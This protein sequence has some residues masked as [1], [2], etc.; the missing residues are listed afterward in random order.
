[1]SELTSPPAGAPVPWTDEPPFDEA[2]LM[3]QVAGDRELLREISGLF[4]AESPRLREDVR[5]AIAAGDAGGLRKAA[6]TLKGA[7]SNFGATA[8]VAAAKA[9]EAMAR[10][11][12]L[13]GAAAGRDRLEEA[14]RRFEEALLRLQ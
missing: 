3:E 11:G 9:L 4:C 13:S 5:S 8:V 7:A 1:M 6:H 2:A 14:L 10:D 12:D